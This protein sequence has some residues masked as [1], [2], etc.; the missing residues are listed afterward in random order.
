MEDAEYGMRVSLGEF[1]LHMK[2]D[3]APELDEGV[4]IRSFSHNGYPFPID[5]IPD[6]VLA[7]FQADARSYLRK[8][9]RE[10]EDTVS[11]CQ[12]RTYWGGILFDLE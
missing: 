1:L 9:A 12:N 10:Q 11:S 6:D 7:L 5:A 4:S 2:F 8:L 3:R